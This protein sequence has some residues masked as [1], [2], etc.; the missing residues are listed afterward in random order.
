MAGCRKELR[1]S[2]ETEPAER[3]S[4]CRIAFM[5]VT[6]RGE[7][8]MIWWEKSKMVQDRVVATDEVEL[9]AVSL[10]LH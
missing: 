2:Y 5:W 3:W 1:L 6:F 8:L 7:S 10:K 9:E 4:T